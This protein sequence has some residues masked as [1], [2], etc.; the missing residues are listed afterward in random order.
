MIRISGVWLIDF[1]KRYGA[2]NIKSITVKAW[3]R[4]AITLDL[5][6]IQKFSLVLVTRESDTQ[7]P[8]EKRGPARIVTP[9]IVQSVPDQ[10]K[11]RVQIFSVKEII[12]EFAREVLYG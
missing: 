3:D 9:I 2:K 8:Y 11:N 12:G 10:I 1:I 6:K 7:I 5:W 4:Y